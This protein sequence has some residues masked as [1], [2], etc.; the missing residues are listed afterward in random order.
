MQSAVH[1]SFAIADNLGEV[2]AKAQIQ[3]VCFDILGLMLAALLN[4]LC[5]NNQRLQAGLPFVAFPIFTAIDLFGIYQGLK[6]VHLQTLTKDRLEI[7]INTWIELGYVPSP[8][9]VSKEEGIDFLWRKG[10]KEWPIRIGCLDVNN[11]VSKLSMLTMRSLSNE[12]FYFICTEISRSGHQGILV[13]VREGASTTDAITGLL[14]ACYFRKRLVM[15]QS[16]ITESSKS[17][18]DVIEESKQCAQADLKVFNEQMAG[19][20]WSV[21]NILLSTHERARYS[22]IED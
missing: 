13:C 21:K 17:L 2:S 3:T 16:N 20:G 9:Q 22:F 1:Q 8:A 5:R 10:R 7:I 15:R 19:V 12:D 11:R 4:I 14:Q 6:H 18:V